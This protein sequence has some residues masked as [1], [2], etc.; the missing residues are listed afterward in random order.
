MFCFIER[1]LNFLGFVTV[2]QTDDTHKKLE[3]IWIERIEHYNN[4][5]R[6][7]NEIISN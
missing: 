5:T 3:N 1:I 4:R 2:V 7:S 6:A